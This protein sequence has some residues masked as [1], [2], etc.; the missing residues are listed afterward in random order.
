MVFFAQI[1][2]AEGDRP[3]ITRTYAQYGVFRDRYI[4]T[5]TGQKLT[6]VE[7][8]KLVDGKMIK[9]L[10]DHPDTYR[11]IIDAGLIALEEGDM[12]RYVALWERE[13]FS[14]FR[15]CSSCCYRFELREDCHSC[16]GMG[17]IEDPLRPSSLPA[18]HP[19]CSGGIF[20]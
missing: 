2:E 17:F 18:S 11:S 6:L 14:I 20:E 13:Q 8:G 15:Q 5:E 4:F 7:T 10:D 19:A 1:H 9:R 12:V 16:K 3:V